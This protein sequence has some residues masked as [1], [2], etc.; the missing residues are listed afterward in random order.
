MSAE[1]T[2]RGCECATD[3]KPTGSEAGSGATRRTQPDRSWAEILR[4]TAFT[5]PD[6]PW[7]TLARTRSTLVPTAA[8]E[9][10]RIARS[11]WVPRRSASSTAASTLASG[12]STL[13][14]ITAS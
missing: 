3:A 10:T 14:A 9:G 11:W 1:T 2:Q 5:K 8:C 13:A 12:R 7:P 6:G 4:S